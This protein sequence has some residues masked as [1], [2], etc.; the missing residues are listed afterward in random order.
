MEASWQLVPSI[1]VLSVTG[2]N[3]TTYWDIHDVNF[4]IVQQPYSSVSVFILSI[5]RVEDI[6]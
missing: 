2:G 4:G 1:N 5:D 6:L 3:A